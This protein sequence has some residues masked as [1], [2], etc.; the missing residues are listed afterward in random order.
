MNASLVIEQQ[1]NNVIGL[2]EKVHPGCPSSLSFCYKPPTLSL[3]PHHLVSSFS[4]YGYGIL[5]K[6]LKWNYLSHSS[7]LVPIS[8]GKG[9]TLQGRSR[10]TD[11]PKVHPCLVSLLTTPTR[12]TT[13][14][15]ETVSNNREGK[16][17]I[18]RGF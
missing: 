15:E 14:F 7:L 6:P 17:N 1:E 18:S 9:E 2:L 10:P 4:S 11:S 16:N 5:S 8:K 12:S 3:A 13:S